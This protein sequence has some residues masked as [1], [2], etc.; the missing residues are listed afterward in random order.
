MLM[1]PSICS[2]HPLPLQ[3]RFGTAKS[4]NLR[5][6]GEIRRLIS[7]SDYTVSFIGP[8]GQFRDYLVIGLAEERGF[9]HTWVRT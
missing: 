2:Q 9:W 3:L 8:D 6:E 7:F 5:F 1:I 4:R